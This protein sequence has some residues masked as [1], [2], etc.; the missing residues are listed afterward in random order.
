MSCECTAAAVH[1][2]GCSL[3]DRRPVCQV[4]PFSQVGPMTC[5]D[6]QGNR[7][8][9]ASLPDGGRRHDDKPWP[10]TSSTSSNYQSGQTP[11]TSEMHIHFLEH[12]IP[13]QRVATQQT[14]QKSNPIYLR[15]LK[16]RPCWLYFDFEY[17]KKPPPLVSAQMKEDGQQQCANRK[18]LGPIGA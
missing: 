6:M 12:A 11:T 16:D 18:I 17:S 13:P 9:Q 8:G 3:V 7:S 1:N 5:Q 10:T 14:N 2:L 15:T 4:C